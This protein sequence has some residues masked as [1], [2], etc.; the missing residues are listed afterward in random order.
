MGL[1]SASNFISTDRASSIRVESTISKIYSISACDIISKTDSD[2]TEC[3]KNLYGTLAKTHSESIAT[4][5]VNKY[6]DK[7]YSCLNEALVN[8]ES[9]VVAYT[10]ECISVNECPDLELIDK[11]NNMCKQLRESKSEVNMES[12]ADYINTLLSES[13]TLKKKV[14]NSILESGDELTVSVN[15]LKSVMSL[16]KSN[17]IGEKVMLTPK[18]FVDKLFDSNM[19]I[20]AINK[21]IP[22]LEKSINNTKKALSE[23]NRLSEEE[24]AKFN[25]KHKVLK[26]A[27]KSLGAAMSIMIG[28]YGIVQLDDNNYDEDVKDLI[29]ES[30]RAL[31]FLKQRKRELEREGANNK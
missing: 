22:K 28:G 31:R 5:T 26:I 30:E 6:I 3:T 4:E 12:T 18:Q 7:V 16:N 13:R 20:H 23:Y 14:Y 15:E 24:K 1:F 19:E 10:N 9:D 8:L 2:I 11:I 29:A 17:V 25:L 27:V 21:R